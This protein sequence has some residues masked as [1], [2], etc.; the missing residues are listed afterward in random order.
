MVD[1]IKRIFSKKTKYKLCL[2]CGYKNDLENEKCVICGG[3]NFADYKDEKRDFRISFIILAILLISSF[4][5]V[6]NYINLG[7]VKKNKDEIPVFVSEKR[8]INYHT[9]LKTL[10]K[11]SNVKPDPHDIEIIERAMKSDD[12]SISSAAA[13][14]MNIWKSRGFVEKK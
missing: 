14:T 12:L 3:S 7:K 9:Y 8:I 6:Y 5:V 13:L 4:V 11:L 10:K 1:K 2:S